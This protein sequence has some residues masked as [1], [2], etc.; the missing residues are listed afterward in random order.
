MSYI[1]KF[2]KARA[3]NSTAA[4][5]PTIT[6]TTTEPSGDGVVN[7][8]PIGKQSQGT[9]AQISFYGVGADNA[10]FNWLIL[11][12]RATTNNLWVPYLLA[13]GAGVLGDFTGTAGADVIATERF[14]DTITV[15]AGGTVNVQYNLL[16]VA[17]SPNCI[18][19]NTNGFAKLEILFE[20]DT[21]TSMN[22]LI[23]FI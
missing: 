9:Q 2:A 14:A 7:V 6:V 3:T 15:A 22:A 4:A 11:G 20:K 17:D 23:A 1:T 5:Y 18:F 8:T 19:L 12:W 16:T 21:T 13:G 10:T